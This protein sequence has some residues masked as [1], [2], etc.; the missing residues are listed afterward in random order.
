MNFKVP[1]GQRAA[2]MSQIGPLVASIM[3]IVLTFAQ[4]DPKF[5]API[6]RLTIPPYEQFARHNTMP[7]ISLN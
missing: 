5:L 1:V 7:P 6:G 2:K 4:V 3:K